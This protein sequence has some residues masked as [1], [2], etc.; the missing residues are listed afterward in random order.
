[1]P[2]NKHVKT[3]TRPALGVAPPQDL[4]GKIAQA[5]GLKQF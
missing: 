3:L 2:R 4:C 5:L 1:M